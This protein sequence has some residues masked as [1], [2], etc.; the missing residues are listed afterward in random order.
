MHKIA[1]FEVLR[2]RIRFLVFFLKK[3]SDFLEIFLT[4]LLYE[5]L[6]YLTILVCSNDFDIL[7]KKG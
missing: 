2:D 7:I 1:V 6:N 5:V 4:F 3:G